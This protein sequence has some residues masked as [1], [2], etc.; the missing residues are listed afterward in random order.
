MAG[1]GRRRARGGVLGA[2][3]AGQGRSRKKE[4][5]VGGKKK[6]KEKGKRKKMKKAKRKRE[7]AEIT[8]V[9]ATGC[10]RLPDGRDARNEREQGDGTA[11]VFGCRDR[12]L[13]ERVPGDLGSSTTNQNFEMI[14]SNFFR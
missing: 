8:A 2:A 9:I 3:R 1:G 13:M 10:A 5:E 14:S 11:I 4:K 7:M 6:K 12:D